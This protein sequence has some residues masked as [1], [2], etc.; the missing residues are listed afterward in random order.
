VAVKAKGFL[1]TCKPQML[2][3]NAAL[4]QIKGNMI[5]AFKMAKV[6]SCSMDGFRLG[7]AHIRKRQM[8]QFSALPENDHRITGPIGPFSFFRSL[9]N[10]NLKFRK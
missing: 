8:P 10:F 6:V 7:L 1:C 4:A 3:Y 2:A 5:C 9:I